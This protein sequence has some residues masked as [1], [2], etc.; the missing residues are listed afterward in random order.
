MTLILLALIILIPAITILRGK[1]MEV[2]K[3]IIMWVQENLHFISSLGRFNF[4]ILSTDNCQII[5][6]CLFFYSD[7]LLAFK[8][9]L[10]FC[11]GQFMVMMFKFFYREPHPY[12]IAPEIKY[13]EAHCGTLKLDYGLPNYM[14]FNLQFL[15]VYINYNYR[16]KYSLGR[17]KLVTVLLSAFYFYNMMST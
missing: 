17:N 7:S 5:M 10:M 16:Y 6:C 15:W 2:E 3:P 1:F 4:I 12:W 9:A 11:I 8:M 13:N 14:L